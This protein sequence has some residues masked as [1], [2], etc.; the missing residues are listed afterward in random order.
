VGGI[1]LADRDCRTGV[2]GLFAAGDAATRELVAGANSGGGAVNSAWAL[3]S[4]R[5]AGAAAAAEARRQGAQASAKGLG[6]YGMHP[7]GEVRAFDLRAINASV[8]EHVHG[9]QRA[10]WR[11]EASLADSAQQLD[12]LWR[13]LAAQSHAS[14]A[15]LVALRET[16]AIL[17]TARWATASALARRESRGLNQREDYRATAPQHAHRLL[18][19]GFETLHVDEAKPLLEA[20]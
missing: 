8:D 17:A 10:F 13:P 19:S 18:V 2:P 12:R 6:R 3:S 15:D 16:I 7:S 4:G 5:I 1:D 14:G 11:K 20:V 9:Y